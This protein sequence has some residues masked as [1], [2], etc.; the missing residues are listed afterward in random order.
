MFR[1]VLLCLVTQSLQI[2][3]HV[4]VLN[5]NTIAPKEDVK[6]FNLHF[7]VAITLSEMQM[8]FFSQSDEN[9]CANVW[10]RTLVISRMISDVMVIACLVYFNTS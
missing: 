2:A 8:I 9:R 3:N 7:L 1:G 5:G 10:W 6:L 4:K